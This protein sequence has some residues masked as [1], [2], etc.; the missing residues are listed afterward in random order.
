MACS[1]VPHSAESAG[2]VGSMNAR[3]PASTSAVPLGA[4]PTPHAAAAAGVVPEPDFR[5]THWSAVLT[6]RDKRSP[7]AQEALAE[8]CRTY[9]YPLYAY[10]RRRGHTHADAEDL[11]QGFFERLLA[12][13]YLGDLT[14]GMGRFRSFLLTALKHFL[15][16]EWDRAQTRKRGGGEVIIS[17]D[18]E[19]VENRYRCE[20][21]DDVSPEVLFERRWA[22]TVL[23]RVLARLRA[24]L[25][26]SEKAGLFDELK[27]YLL[28]D[29]TAGSYAEV[30]ARLGMKEGTIKVAV[31]RL[32][33]RFGE[34][35]R[36]TIAETVADPGE[37]EDEV[38]QLIAAVAR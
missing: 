28:G 34:L 9:W 26:A 15:A 31:H 13:D 35:L 30:A 33:R 11:T 23:D 2:I 27:G 20:P 19:A 25:A 4:G 6:A 37:V 24:E 8:L 3:T 5:T 10:I 29:E 18:D 16:N 7:Q 32:R 1:N 36:A 38:R 14:P 12:K 22:L 21:T 17:L